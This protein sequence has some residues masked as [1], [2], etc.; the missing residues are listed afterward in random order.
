MTANPGEPLVRAPS[1]RRRLWRWV[2]AFGL[3]LSDALGIAYFQRDRIAYWLG[4]HEV[5]LSEPRLERTDT[6]VVKHTGPKGDVPPDTVY[7]LVILGPKGIGLWGMDEA[8]S[9][10]AIR[11]APRERWLTKIIAAEEIRH[12]GEL[13]VKFP[14][15]FKT[16]VTGILDCYVAKRPRTAEDDEPKRPGLTIK[17]GVAIEEA[18]AQRVSNI[19]SLP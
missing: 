15:E 1:Q 12:P 17:I 14:M 18:P 5:F 9:A 2:V 11:E 19:V 8:P 7:Q 3:A 10:K 16:V 13:R 4:H 6:I